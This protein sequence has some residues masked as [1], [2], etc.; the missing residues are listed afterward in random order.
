MDNVKIMLGGTPVR[1]GGMHN[2]VPI[3]QLTQE[4]HGRAY[5]RWNEVCDTAHDLGIQWS[6]ATFCTLRNY[7][8]AAKRYG[9]IV[10]DTRKRSGSNQPEGWITVS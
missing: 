2:Y 3:V 1:N 4:K 8:E 7:H 9:L 10:T 6:S 5:V